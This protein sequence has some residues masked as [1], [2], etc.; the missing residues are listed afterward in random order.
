MKEMKI[1]NKT[2][3]IVDGDNEVALTLAGYLYDQNNKIVLFGSDEQ[4]LRAALQNVQGVKYIVGKVSDQESIQKLYDYFGRGFQAIDVIVQVNNFGKTYAE[5]VGSLKKGPDGKTAMATTIDTTTAQEINFISP[6][7]LQE[8]FI[9]IM[10]K[11]RDAQ[12]ITVFCGGFKKHYKF[13]PSFLRIKSDRS[14]YSQTL[15]HILSQTPVKVTDVF[16]SDTR[17]SERGLKRLAEAFEKG[18]NVIYL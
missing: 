5:D 1:E 7:K 2:I 17:L 6:E 13:I 3:L 14:R 4:K 15:R 9:P 12:V 18:K 16:M 8:Y 10:L 11:E